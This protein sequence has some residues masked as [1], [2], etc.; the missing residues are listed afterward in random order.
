MKKPKAVI[1][2]LNG[3]FIQSEKLSNRFQ[4]KYGVENK[5]FFSALK[6]I[7]GKVRLLKVGNA[8]D[9]WKPYLERWGVGLSE[10]EFFQFWFSGEKENI[11]MIELAKAIKGSGKKIFILS[12]NFRERTNFYN[13]SFHFLHE[14]PEKVYYS[15]QTGFLK[16]DSRAY[17]L[18]LDE[19]NLTPNQ[20]VF[21]DD[22]KENVEIARSVGIQGYIFSD[23]EDTKL[24]LGM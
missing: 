24:K 8:F 9:Y 20:V 15:W 5:V 1:F 2:D 7:M 21:F 18:V 19:N 17:R 14:I 13:N 3:V 4:E 11:K 16:S 22:S 23:V 12:N 10:Q 6:E